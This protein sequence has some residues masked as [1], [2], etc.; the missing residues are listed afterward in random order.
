MERGSWRMEGK[1]GDLRYK[2]IID[3]SDGSRY[4]YPQDVVMELTT[5]QVTA[6][7]VP[8]RPRLFGLLGR[9]ED[10]IIPWSQVRQVGEDIIL[11]E[12]QMGHGGRPVGY[13]SQKRY[14]L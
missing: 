14:D 7:V 8:G 4:G 5:G 12:G 10:I 3:V 6:L 13:L 1:I 2:E 11:V 9:E